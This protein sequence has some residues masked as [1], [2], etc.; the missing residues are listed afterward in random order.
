MVDASLNPT[1][2]KSSAP[3]SKAPVAAPKIDPAPAAQV[4]GPSVESSATAPATASVADATSRQQG[5][6]QA[7]PIVSKVSGLA[8]YRD[9]ESGRLVVQIFDQ[10]RGDVILE[11]PS[12]NMLR[13][14][15][16]ASPSQS[17]DHVIE[18]KA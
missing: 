11:F 7:A 17:I 12:E 8:T 4:S 3:A 9:H 1:G 6:Q 5:S 2:Q 15:P 18:T 10:K 14:Y 13:A 16:T